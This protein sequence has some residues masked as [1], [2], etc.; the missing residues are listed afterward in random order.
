MT[1]SAQGTND[2]RVEVSAGE[3]L[4]KITILQIK[5]S[6]IQDA[7]KLQNINRELASLE[8]T[9]AELI[10]DSQ[11]LDQLIAELRATNETLWE[12]EDDIRECERQREFG[13]EFVQL[14]RRVYITN[15]KRSELKREINE[16]LGSRL[17]EEKS[18]S[19]Y[20]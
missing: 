6:Q 3:L 15:D 11:A 9:R 12:I 13:D 20:E 17:V 5:R 4:D 16:L 1:A 7:Q 19:H 14:A 18:Y 2:I 10:P 8:Q